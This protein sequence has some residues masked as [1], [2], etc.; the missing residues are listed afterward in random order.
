MSLIA[1][2]ISYHIIRVKRRPAARPF[3]ESET[4]RL[5]ES[6]KESEIERENKGK[7]D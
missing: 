1:V 4:K 2:L 7:R 3:R 6:G 5:R